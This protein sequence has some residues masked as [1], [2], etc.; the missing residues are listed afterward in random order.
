MRDEMK[1]TWTEDHFRALFE[2]GNN[3]EE[4]LEAVR[5]WSERN[6]VCTQAMHNIDDPEAFM[7]KLREFMTGGARLRARNE[8]LVASICKDLRAGEKP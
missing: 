5:Q 3:G 6:R 8:H 1:P 7:Q 2:M 4:R